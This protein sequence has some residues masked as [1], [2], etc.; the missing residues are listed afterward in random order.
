MS[1]LASWIFIGIMFFIW[2]NLRNIRNY[3]YA[4]QEYKRRQ[5][6][7]LKILIENLSNNQDEQTEEKDKH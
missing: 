6:I 5:L 7:L 3:L 1:E 4:L 2:L